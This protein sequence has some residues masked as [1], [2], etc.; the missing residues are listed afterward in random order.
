MSEFQLGQKLYAPTKTGNVKT[1]RAQVYCVVED[2]QATATITITT[3]TKLDG[4]E[5]ERHDVIT[6]GKNLGKSNETTPYEQAVSEAESRYRK[7]LKDGYSTEI[8]TDTSQ[9]SSNAL[10]LPRPMLAHPIDKVKKVEFPA[11]WQAKLNGHRALVT[12]RNGE[13]MMY[14]RKGERI[15]TMNHILTHLEDKVEEGIILDG[16]LYIHGMKLQDIGKLVKKW[17]PESVN[18]QYH[19][20]DMITDTPYSQRYEHLFT[21]IGLADVDWPVQLV[22]TICVED[23][24]K[25]QR[26]TDQAIEDGYEGGILRTPDKGY[27][28]GFRSRQLLKMKTFDD[29]EFTVVDI[30]QGKTRH[31]ND[32][33][34]EVAILVCET[35]DGKRFEVTAHGDM[36]EKDRIWHE[37]DN[38]VGRLVTVKYYDITKDGIPFHP[39]ALQWREDI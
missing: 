38:H 37:R 33:S 8:P 12:R 19:V 35:S 9:A 21:V 20:Y 18:V 3:Q 26:L 36:Y 28:A 27:L 10:G 13:L 15:T 23:M 29:A 25:A 22:T 32:V 24:E 11:H 5:V 16:E 1:W 6:E 14:S 2:P 30:I 7:K 34:L 31:V 4:K 39:V 17:R